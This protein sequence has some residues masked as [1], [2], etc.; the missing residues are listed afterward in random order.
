[1]KQKTTIYTVAAAGAVLALLVFLY[2]FYY[3]PRGDRLIV[4]G[5][6]ELDPIENSDSLAD[7]ERAMRSGT[8]EDVDERLPFRGFAN[9][10]IRRML[11]ALLSD[12]SAIRKEAVLTFNSDE[13]Y[14]RFLN[15]LGG[16]N[17]RLLGSSDSLRSVRLGFD[18]YEDF[19]NALATLD[20]NE[21][22]SEMNY[23][24]SL[25]LPPEHRNSPGAGSGAIP[26]GRNALESLGISGDHSAFGR[27]VL[28]A[29]LDSGIQDHVAFSGKV[30]RELDYVRDGNGKPVPIDIDNGHGTA[31][32]SIIAGSDPLL[33][34]VAP[35]AG[36]LSYRILDNEG[37]TNSFT[38]AEA[39]VSAA[40]EGADI[41]NVSLGSTGDSAL[42]RQAVDYANS[43]GALIVA[44]TGNDGLDQ[45]T[46]PAAIDGVIAVSA[47]DARGQHLDFAN[48]GA[49]LES[50][51]MA[52]PGYG[53]VAAWPD[54]QASNFSGTS[55]SAPYVSGAVAA[56]MSENPGMSAQAAYELLMVHSNE[57]GAPGSDDVY[58]SGNLNIGRVLN[59]N[60]PGIVDVAV[61]SYYYDPLLALSNG[62]E[63]IAQVIVENRG[64][65]PLHNV[66]VDINSGDGARTYNVAFIP[67]GE[68][69]LIPAPINAAAGRSAGQLEVSATASVNP[70]LNDP[71]LNPGDNSLSTRIEF[72]EESA[73]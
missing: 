62:T 66:S 33:P 61:A 63:N 21:T 3:A 42:V 14:Q 19:A 57:A 38:L 45:V 56:V 39:I 5:A 58:G 23:L 48:S 17:L 29:V 72:R 22:S 27:G 50:G 64:T 51:G 54:G 34:G 20:P 6:G 25:P 32:A 31:V 13:A 16:R 59:R 53:V 2:L 28:V 35:S 68:S 24:V 26:F 8:D 7:L 41:I 15:S 40:D 1:M 52:A 73:P 49:S 18:R 36:L 30:I 43:K 46:Y 9:R 37:Y 70:G 12:P 67:A 71:D 60:S 65:E 4:E 44:A 47:V 10:V 69:Y 55:A 11:E